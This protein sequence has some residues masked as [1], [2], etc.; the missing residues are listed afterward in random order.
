M[1]AARWR[2]AGLAFVFLWFA[3]GGVAHFAL[4]DTEM[5]IVPPWMPW[6]RA[7]VLASGV[8]ELLGAAGLLWRPTRRAAGIGLF[9]LTIAVTPAHFYMLQQSALFPTVPYWALLLRLPI[10]VALLALIAW[11]TGA[12]APRRTR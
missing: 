3:I 4:T 2:I 10:Q 11:S 9:V 1:T 7:A 5:R 8:F 6:P 12:F